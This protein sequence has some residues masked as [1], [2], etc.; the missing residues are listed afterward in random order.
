[1]VS[2][3]RLFN[4]SGESITLEGLTSLTVFDLVAVKSGFL[5]RPPITARLEAGDFF[6][7]LTGK[8]P[9]TSLFDKAL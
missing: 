5:A 2:L 4:V 1:L 3:C 6:F 9:I 8:S 7:S